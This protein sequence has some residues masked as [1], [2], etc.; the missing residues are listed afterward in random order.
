MKYKIARRL[1]CKYVTRI[2]GMYSKYVVDTQGR[3][4]ILKSAISKEIKH[5]PVQD[6][7]E[8]LEKERR[9]IKELYEQGK[10]K[11]V[12]SILYKFN[13]LWGCFKTIFL[14]T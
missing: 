4:R 7:I 2:K 13:L 6:Q 12:N 3:V 11:E 14:N 5:L 9:I 8:L 1:E 10:L